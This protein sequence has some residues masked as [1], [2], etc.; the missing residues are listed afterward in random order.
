M[1]KIVMFGGEK[2]GAGKSTTAVNVA[3]YLATQGYDVMLLDGDKQPS[4]SKFITRRNEAGYTPTIHNTQK[5]G[6][7]FHTARDL[8]DRYDFVVIDAGGRDSK[9]LRTGLVAT[10]LLYTPLRASQLDVET[11][12]VVDELVSL[13]RGMNPGLQA[14]ILLCMVPSTSINTEM[15]EAKKLFGNFPDLP[16]SDCYI[17]DYKI[18]RDAAELGKGVVEMKNQK[19]KAEIQL[20]GQELMELL[21]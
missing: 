20:L 3:V 17:A 13:A 7:I 8:A 4:A 1:G 21:K 11:L 2:G 15:A 14:R 16:V 18:Y 6:D 5:L 9:E 10:D 19:A 12:P